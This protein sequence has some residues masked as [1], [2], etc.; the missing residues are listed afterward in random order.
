M[1]SSISGGTNPMLLTSTEDR[2]PRGSKE[3]PFHMQRKKG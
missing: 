3:I 2:Y 1:S